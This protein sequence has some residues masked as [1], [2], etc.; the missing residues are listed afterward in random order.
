MKLPTLRTMTLA[1]AIAGLCAAC[2]AVPPGPP[3]D[4]VRLQNELDRLHADPR[5]IDNAGSELGNADAAVDTLARNAGT[6]DE[7]AYQQGVYV[8]GKLVQIAEASAMARYAERRGAELGAERDRL[9]AR[10]GTRG[11]AAVAGG[12]P[13]ARAD[14]LAMQSRL[15]GVESRID[16]RGLVVRLGD[17]MFEPGRPVLTRSGEQALDSLA[18]ALRSEPQTVARVEE[19]GGPDAPASYAR[20]AAVRGYLNARGVELARLDVRNASLAGAGDGHVDVIVRSSGY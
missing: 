1:G 3:P 19:Y 11:P 7:H 10:A 18:Y 13:P 14:L 12:P 2:A 15:G 8:A 6:L 17:Y 9:L 20:A 5:I 4:V 16:E